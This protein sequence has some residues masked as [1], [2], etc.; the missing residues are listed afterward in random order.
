MGP[1]QRGWL[2]VC[3]RQAGS[4]FESI[5]EP[6]FAEVCSLPVNNHFHSWWFVVARRLRLLHVLK[7]LNS[8]G[9]TAAS[10]TVWKKRHP[11]SSSRQ[12]GT[13]WKSSKQSISEQGVGAN[14][15]GDG[16]K[17]AALKLRQATNVLETHVLC[18]SAGSDNGHRAVTYVYWTVNADGVTTVRVAS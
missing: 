6:I 3:K 10:V 7:R 9:N 17:A 8:H 12:V 16:R 13:I 4:H 18:S 2:N 1:S 14:R 5:T 11:Q 15:G